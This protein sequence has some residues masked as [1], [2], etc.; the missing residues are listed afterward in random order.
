RPSADEACG[1][2]LARNDGDDLFAIEP[3]G[4]AQEGLV[5]VV[6]VRI[7]VC[8]VPGDTPVGPDGVLT[9]THSHVLGVPQRPA[10]EG[11]GALL[12][13]L[14]SVVPNAH[15]EQLEQFT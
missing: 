5:T 10:G 15:G 13:I 14:L 9:G 6:V 1:G 7:A 8:K 3:A 4:L 2:L 12:N 11:T